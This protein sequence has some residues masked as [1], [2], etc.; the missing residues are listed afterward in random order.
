M[1]NQ[2]TKKINQEEKRKE[3]PKGKEQYSHNLKY[4]KDQIM[5]KPE[6][7][8]QQRNEQKHFNP[9]ARP[10][11]AGPTQKKLRQAASPPKSPKFASNLNKSQVIV[12]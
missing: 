10:K 5:D 1:P 8:K 2:S 12:Q 4:Q 6:Y 11:S 7:T 9:Q 3:S